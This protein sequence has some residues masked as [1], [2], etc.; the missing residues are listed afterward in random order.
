MKTYALKK[1]HTSITHAQPSLPK[2]RMPIPSPYPSPVKDTPR[3]SDPQRIC[4]R[5][6]TGHSQTLILVPSIYNPQGKALGVNHSARTLNPSSYTCVSS[7]FGQ[8][9]FC[10]LAA[11]LAVSNLES[12]R[13]S[14]LSIRSP[15][16]LDKSCRP[17]KPSNLEL[18]NP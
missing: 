15:V 4:T 18:Q 14:S 9:E 6:K 7:S 2:D 5:T 12:S 16:L 13:N 17:K 3:N 11:S 1:K 10:T 8:I